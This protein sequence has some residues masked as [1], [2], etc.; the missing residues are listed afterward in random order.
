MNRDGIKF[1]ARS[2]LGVVRP[3][4]MGPKPYIQSK[5]NQFLKFGPTKNHIFYLDMVGFEVIFFIQ[6]M[7]Q[8]WIKYMIPIFQIHD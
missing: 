8:I 4:N 7:D 5:P 6:N 1:M 2:L 3:G